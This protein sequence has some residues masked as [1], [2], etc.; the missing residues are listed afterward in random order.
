MNK[1]N[2]KQIM[3][4]DTGAGG[5]KT[6]NVSF[7]SNSNTSKQKPETKAVTNAKV[8][9]NRPSSEYLKKFV[10]EDL[11][12][13]GSYLLN[14]VL[15]PA[16]KSLIADVVQN[17]IEKLLFGEV[18]NAKNRYNE[19]SKPSTHYSSVSYNRPTEDSRP[20]VRRTYEDCVISTRAEAEEVLYQLVG[21]CREYG[22][23]SVADL[24]SLINITGEFTD[25][26]YGWTDLGSAS[27][28]PV[29][30]GYILILPRVKTIN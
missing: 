14:D 3:K 2:P 18:R 29:R 17:G 5:Q 24:H 16:I 27:I 20:P 10:Q 8:V 23:A 12:S 4:V 13:V 22:Q 6:V 28:R 7:P 9:K 21:I 1:N 30:G 11:G 19:Y 25:N 15:R 26:R